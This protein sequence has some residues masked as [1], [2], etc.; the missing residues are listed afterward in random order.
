M[1]RIYFSFLIL[2]FLFG[3]NKPNNNNRTDD[4]LLGK[5]RYTEYYLSA[6]G[7]G[8]WNLV[9]PTGQYIAFKANGNFISTGSFSNTFNSY[10]IID[11]ARVKFK[12]ASKSLGFG[13]EN[14]E[15]PC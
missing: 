7:P 10:E 12:P 8:Q 14:V 15:Y 6:G 4:V 1:H 9:Q 11:R 2:L 3:C 5:W 13:K